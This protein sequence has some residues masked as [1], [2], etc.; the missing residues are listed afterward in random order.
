MGMS[1][2]AEPADEGE[3][4][5]HRDRPGARCRGL[6]GDVEGGAHRGY[7]GGD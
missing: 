2:P 6:G 3:G 7:R 4:V 5:A 1:A